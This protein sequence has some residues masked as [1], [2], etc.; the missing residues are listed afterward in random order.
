M[1]NAETGRVGTRRHLSGYPTDQKLS[2]TSAGVRAYPYLP[3]A[4]ADVSGGIIL[5]S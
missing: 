5:L 1:I 2:E 4:C 3:E